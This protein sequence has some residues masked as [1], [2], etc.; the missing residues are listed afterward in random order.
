LEA[1]E[2]TGFT[3]LFKFFDDITTAVGNI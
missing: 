2:L 3:P 1:Y